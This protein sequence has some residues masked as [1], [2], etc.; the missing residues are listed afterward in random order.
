[1]WKVALGLGLVGLVGMIVGAI[2]VRA[3][4]G[5][6]R[7]DIAARVSFDDGPLAFAKT[8]HDGTVGPF[9]I[10]A[11]RVAT[12]HEL[13]RMALLEQDLAQLREAK[14]TWRISL[15]AK[16]GGY[17]TDTLAFEDERIVSVKAYYSHFAGL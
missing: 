7:P 9:R 3:H 16:D 17:A 10:G 13:E 11:S 2:A 8:Y 6:H 14:P 4:Y 12:T 1:M 15:P 5:R